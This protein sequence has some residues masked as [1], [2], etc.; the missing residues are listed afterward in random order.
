MTL[1]ESNIST[2]MLFESLKGD[3]TINQH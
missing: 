2:P 1:P 3:T